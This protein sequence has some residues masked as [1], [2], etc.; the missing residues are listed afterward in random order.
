MA[1]DLRSKVSGS[2]AI[3]TDLWQRRRKWLG[4]GESKVF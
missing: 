2:D 4:E 1:V 3:V